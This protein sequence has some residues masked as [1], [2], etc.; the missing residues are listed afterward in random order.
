LGVDGNVS[1][2]GDGTHWIWNLSSKL[3][4]NT[5]ECL[6]IF[7]VSEQKE[8]T[9]SL[10][11]YLDNNRERLFEGR[12]IGSGVCERGVQ[13]FSGAE[14]KTD[15]SMLAETTSRK[16]GCYLRRN[17]LK[18]M[19]LLLENIKIPPLILHPRLNDTN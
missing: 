2:L 17:I 4:G 7:H 19:E 1:V 11:T 18:T 9:R 13:K 6:D 16:D 10:Q 8:A 12:A 15:G 5:T 14:I 3:F